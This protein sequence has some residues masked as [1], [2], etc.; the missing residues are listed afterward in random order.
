MND[1]ISINRY[2]ESFKDTFFDSII[3]NAGI[4]DLNLIES[5]SDK[6]I[7]DSLNINLVAPIKL[8]RGF[9]GEMKNNNYGRI[10]NVGSIWSV[11]SKEGRSVYSATKNAIHGV[12]NCLSV[13]LGQNN[14]LVNTVCPGYTLTE[15]TYN[16]NTKEQIDEISKNIPLGRMAEPFEIA[17]L[18]Y[19]LGSED[20]SYITGQKIVIDGGFSVK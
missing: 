6:E 10:V 7:N 2:I 14:I 18:I 8:I 9:I 15:L 4:N 20:N 12:T 17:K 5:V 1:S 16:N 3:N 19:F 11:V 13:E